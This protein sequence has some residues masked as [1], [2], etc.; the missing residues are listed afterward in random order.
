M[1][2]ATDEDIINS[3]S[4]KSFFFPFLHHFQGNELSVLLRQR[5]ENHHVGARVRVQTIKSKL[6][7]A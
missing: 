7:L 3:R 6:L 5:K 4:Q 2:V 1:S